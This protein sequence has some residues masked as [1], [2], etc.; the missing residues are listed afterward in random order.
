NNEELTS[1]AVDDEIMD[2]WT[3]DVNES[4][5]NIVYD[6]EII[7]CL[8]QKC[9]GLISMIKRSTIITLFFDTERKKTKY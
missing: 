4:D 8:M 1:D 6:Q 5:V 2:N 3:E 7:I 9:R